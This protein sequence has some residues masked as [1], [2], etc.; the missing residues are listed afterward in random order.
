M[1]T[2]VG[3]SGSTSWMPGSHDGHR[4]GSLNN[5]QTVSTGASISTR[6]EVRTGAWLSTRPRLAYS[7][8]SLSIDGP[9]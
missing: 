2:A 4:V 3:A 9:R 1:S 7:S 5:A 6:C 8:W